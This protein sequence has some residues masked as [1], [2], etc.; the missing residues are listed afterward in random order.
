MGEC[1]E[2]GSDETGPVFVVGES[3]IRRPELRELVEW[4]G[5]LVIRVL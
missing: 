3:A 4:Q 1:E 5:H 2:D